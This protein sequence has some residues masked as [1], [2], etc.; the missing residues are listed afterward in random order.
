VLVT[1]D[2]VVLDLPAASA[3][4]AVLDVQRC[5]FSTVLMSPPPPVQQY[6]ASVDAARLLVAH[7]ATSFSAASEHRFVELACLPRE[8]A[9]VVKVTVDAELAAVAV[10]VA[11]NEINL[12][13]C[14]DSLATFQANRFR[15][16][17]R[18]FGVFFKTEPIVCSE[19]MYLT[20]YRLRRSGARCRRGPPRPTS[21]GGSAR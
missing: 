8:K 19:G 16:R 1:A 2:D 5:S 17:S 14:A 20:F 13:F 3:S 18:P 15:Q 10:S 4:Q 7:Q 9:V 21:P 6:T 11:A 12:A